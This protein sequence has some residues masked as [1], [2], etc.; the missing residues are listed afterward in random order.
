MS[1]PVLLADPHKDVVPTSYV[2]Q[3]TTSQCVACGHIG[4]SCETY[5]R[6]WMKGQWGKPFSN[7]RPLDKPKYKLPIE[8]IM[9]PI[10]RVPFCDHCQN[11]NSVLECLEYPPA[12]AP[13]KTIVGSAQAPD[14]PTKPTVVKT[15]RDKV[16]TDDLLDGLDL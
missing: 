8:R 4:Q 11:P 16:T 14:K 3:V 6:T 7:M 9:R 13:S 12:P 2:I 1:N 15:K 5:A 10:V